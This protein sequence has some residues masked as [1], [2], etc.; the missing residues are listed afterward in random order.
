MVRSQIREK[1]ESIH[2]RIPIEKYRR[3]SVNGEF[4]VNGARW[5]YG[6]TELFVPRSSLKIPVGHLR[7]L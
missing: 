2:N 1:Y 3:F 4:L 7:V 6:S 5:E